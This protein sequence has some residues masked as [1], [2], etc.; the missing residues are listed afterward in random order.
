[1]LML[2]CRHADMMRH[3]F[4]AALMLLLDVAAIIADLR[5]LLT[6]MIIAAMPF[7]LMRRRYFRCR[8]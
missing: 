5:F 3:Y 6:L 4:R 7:R 8:C 2:I 1:M